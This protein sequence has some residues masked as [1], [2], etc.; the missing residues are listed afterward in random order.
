MASDET[1]MTRLLEG[2]DQALNTLVERYQG[3]LYGFALRML[4][5]PSAAED[6]FQ[7]TFLKVY[8]KRWSFREGS[9]FRPWIYQICLNV[10]RDQLRRNKRRHEIPLTDESVGA[11]PAPGPEELAEKKLQAHRV[12]V[13]ISELPAKQRE[14]LVLAQYQGLNHHEISQ[15]L[16]IPE[17]TVKSRKFNAIRAL[18]KV[19][20]KK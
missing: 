9:L 16:N 3:P 13:A 1:L 7:E 8:R 19:L 12:G 18:A 17:G 20:K 15:I 11:D 10:C 5:E 14:V 4:S 2:Q 6:A